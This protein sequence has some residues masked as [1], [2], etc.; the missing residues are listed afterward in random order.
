LLLKNLDTSR[1]LVNGAKG[2]VIGFE[3]QPGFS[4][5]Q[6][7]QQMNP[8]YV[9]MDTVLPIVEFEIKNGTRESNTETRTLKREKWELTVF[10]RVVASRVQ[11][12]LMLAW[13]ISIH[14]VRTHFLYICFCSS[15]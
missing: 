10:D 1:G 15:G 8:N 12:P 3:P 14:K 6:Q 4:S 9:G 13:A 5:E 7:N 2:I 11:I